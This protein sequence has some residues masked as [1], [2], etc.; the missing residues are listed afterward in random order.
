MFLEL[1]LG[2]VE[3]GRGANA[4]AA[5]GD[6]SGE[7]LAL[8]YSAGQD[9]S[10]KIRAGKIDEID[11][12]NADFGD[13]GIQRGAVLWLDS[14]HCGSGLD[15]SLPANLAVLADEQYLTPLRIAAV[16][17]HHCTYEKQALH[18]FP[19]RIFSANTF[20]SASTRRWSWARRR[21]R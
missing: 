3:N 6:F 11:R 17:K 21:S 14:L 2:E 16:Q 18:K 12:R 4:A 1:R 9:A 20:C 13:V 15:I 19:P 10:G 7:V 8:L 5:L